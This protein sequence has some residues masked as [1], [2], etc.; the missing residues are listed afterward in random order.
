[1]KNTK[2]M[3]FSKAIGL[4]FILCIIYSLITMYPNYSSSFDMGFS[5]GSAFG[6]AIKILGAIGLIVYG[7]RTIKK[8]RIK[9]LE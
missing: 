4:I 9:T 6:Y 5:A 2:R 8:R 3:Q 7:I 1:M